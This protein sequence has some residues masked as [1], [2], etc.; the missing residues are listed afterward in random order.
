MGVSLVFGLGILYV[1]SPFGKLWC[2]I[3]REREAN[4]VD[5]SACVSAGF[6]LGVTVTYGYD[7]DQMYTLGPVVFWVIAETTCGFFIVCMPCLPKILKEKGIIRRVKGWFGMRVTTAGPS[8][9]GY[10]SELG[11]YPGGSR[12][13]SGMDPY[14]KLDESNSGKAMRSVTTNTDSMENL[15]DPEEGNKGKIMKTTQVVVH[16]HQDKRSQSDSEDMVP[17]M[18]GGRFY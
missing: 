11:G 15:R 7:D 3:M 17:G 12:S 10:N 6:R 18:K 4:F 1:H 13:A 14:L 8:S 9:Y 5:N 2:S 16:Y